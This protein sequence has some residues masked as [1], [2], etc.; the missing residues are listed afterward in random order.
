MRVTSLVLGALAVGA[1]IGFLSARII[2]PTVTNASVDSSV[3]HLNLNI[4][5]NGVYKVRSVVDGDTIVLENGL[6]LRYNGL[7]APETGRWIR[8]YSPYSREATERNIALVEGKRIR[9][10]LA[11]D[12]MDMHG[13][14]VA[15]VFVVPDDPAQPEIEVRVPMIKEGFAKAMGLGVSHGEYQQLK[16]LQ[17]EAK[18][19]RKGMWGAADDLSKQRIETAP[20]AFCA[21]SNSKIYHRAECSTAKRINATYLHEYATAAEAEAVGLKPCSRCLNGVKASPEKSAD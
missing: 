14:V 10:K 5:D 9:L 11:P 13:R 7:N 6:H 21:S 12:P 8:D 17:D 19:A 4:V 3:R 15:N 1:T 2:F 18:A 20:K 16:E